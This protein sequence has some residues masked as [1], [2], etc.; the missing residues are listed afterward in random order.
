MRYSENI[1]KEKKKRGKLR[2]L[3]GLSIEKPLSV[4]LSFVTHF[5]ALPLCLSPILGF[6]F[7]F[8]FSIGQFSILINAGRKEDTKKKRRRRK[9]EKGEKERL[10]AGRTRSVTSNKR[11]FFIV[12]MCVR[13][14][15]RACHHNHAG[16]S[17]GFH[18]WVAAKW[19][20]RGGKKKKQ[21]AAVDRVKPKVRWREH[22]RRKRN[23]ACVPLL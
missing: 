5:Y 4:C 11:S 17:S 16:T 3:A 9:Q 20:R 23:A 15:R 8:F 12:C 22:R 7:S 10:P 18:T 13:L 6:F 14:L 2:R 19:K 21:N 1:E